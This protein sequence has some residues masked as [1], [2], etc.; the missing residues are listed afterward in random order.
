ME[1]WNEDEGVL[2][3]QLVATHEEQSGQPAGTIIIH[4]S[5]PQKSRD[6][7]SFTLSVTIG[8]FTVGKRL[9]DLGANISLC[10]YLCWRK[11]EMLKYC[12]EDDITISW[13]INKVSTWNSWRS[14]SE[15][16]R[17]LFSSWL[18]NH[19]HKERLLKLWLMWM[20]NSWKFEYQMKKLALMYLKLWNIWLTREIVLE[21]MYLMNYIWKIKGKYMK[22]FL[23]W[24]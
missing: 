2:D 5:L 17:I 20:K 16:R 9:L 19:I 7:G 6:P 10:L 22:M 11:L 13:H 24:K 15:G 3:T 12:C 21:W 8:N 1:T 23:L 4:K 18:C 14:F